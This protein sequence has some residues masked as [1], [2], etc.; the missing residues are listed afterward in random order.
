MDL[1]SARR[2][3]H[4]TRNGINYDIRFGDDGGVF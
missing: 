4:Q 1:L 2:E 3:S